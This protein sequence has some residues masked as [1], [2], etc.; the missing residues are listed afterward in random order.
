MK[1]VDEILAFIKE[2]ST[3]EDWDKC[4][5]GTIRFKSISRESPRGACPI[6]WLASKLGKNPGRNA[7]DVLTVAKDMEL[8]RE[9][10]A[11]IVLAADFKTQKSDYDPEIRRRLLDACHLPPE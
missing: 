10:F 8:P 9:A 2:N 6:C 7:L 3:E 4:P 11:P 1:N 5:W